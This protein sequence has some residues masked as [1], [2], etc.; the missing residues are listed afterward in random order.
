MKEEVFKRLKKLRG[1]FTLPRDKRMGSEAE[2][3][4]RKAIVRQEAAKLDGIKELSELMR[5]KIGDIT[6]MLAWDEK[7]K[8]DQ[9]QDLFVERG[10]YQYLVSFFTDAEPTIKGIEKMVEENL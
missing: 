4:L 3:S 2:K 6:F 1:E 10:C 7:I 5:E 8:E 9:R